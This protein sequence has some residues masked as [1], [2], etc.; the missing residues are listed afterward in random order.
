M[1]PASWTP[2]RRDD[3]ETLGWIRP[4]GELWV[5]VDRLGRDLA[6][7]SEWLDAEQVLEERGLGW[8]AGRW[9]LDGAPVRI[10]ELDEDRILVVT[11][12]YGGASAVGARSRRSSCRGRLRRDCRRSSRTRRS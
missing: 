5:A 7:A 10:A 6:G 8:L 9:W 11:D 4:E 2:H 12:Y 3:G 1:L